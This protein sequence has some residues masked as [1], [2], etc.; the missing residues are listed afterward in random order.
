MLFAALEALEAA[1]RSARNRTLARQLGVVRGRLQQ[2]SFEAA[3]RL[4][5]QLW[6]GHPGETASLAPVYARL[7]L[8]E[9]REP[10]AALRVLARIEEPDAD[11]AAL[12]AHAYGLLRRADDAWRVLSAAL[13]TYCVTPGGLLSRQL[14][15]TLGGTG[16]AAPGWIGVGPTLEFVG[17]LAPG[18]AADT[19]EF[20]FANAP[21]RPTLHLG[22]HA[23]RAQFRFTL[24]DH[25][26]GG[27]LAICSG[28]TPLLGGDQQLPLDFA[29]DGRV[30]GNRQRL[31]G[32]VRVGWL[33]SRRIHLRAQD[34]TGATC[35]IQ[36]RA[37]ALPGHRWPFQLH[38]GRNSL[39][40]KYIV[41]QAR[42]PDKRWQSLPDAPF[43]LPQLVRGAKR[44]AALP[45]W[46]STAGAKV[47]PTPTHL[48][49]PAPIAVVIPAY[50]GVRETLA[51]IESVRSTAPEARLIVV[52]DATPEP[53][54]GAGLD[55]LAA[56]GRIELLRNPGNL[57]FVCSVNRALGGTA[58]H[59]VVLLNSDT[60]VFGDWLQRLRS[61]AYSAGQVGTVTPLCNDGSIASYPQRYGGPIGA[62]EA[63]ELD[64][65]AARTDPP[66]SAEIPVGVGFCMFI[67]HDCLKATGKFDAAIFGVG[68]GEESDFCLRAREHGWSHRLAANV[69]VYHTGGGSFGRRRM[70]LLERSQRLLNLRHPGYNR[71]VKQFMKQ[72]PLLPLRRRLDEQRLLAL[73]GSGV[74]IVT[75]ALEGGVERFVTERKRELHA[76]GLRSLVLKPQRPGDTRHVEICV[77]GTDVPNLCYALPGDLDALTA[78]LRRLRLERIE[79]QHFLDLDPAVIDSV[80]SLQVPCDVVIHDYSWIC[81]RITLINGTGRY[82]G[83]PPVSHCTACVRKNGSRLPRSLST[84]ALRARSERWLA[85]ARTVTAPS[86]DAAERMR[87]YFKRDFEVRPHAPALLHVD[88]ATAEL[89]PQIAAGRRVRV[90]VVGAIGSHKGFQILLQCARDAAERDLP[91]E[92]V[93]VGYTENDQLLL[94]T[95]RVEVTG[96]YD[97]AEVAYLLRRERP[98]LVFL[99]SVWPETWCY[100]LDHAL[101]S[102]IR[103]VAFSVGAMTERLRA[104]GS[105]DLLPL[106]LSAEQ[107]NERL[108]QLGTGNAAVY[109]ETSQPQRGDVPKI[110]DDEGRITMKKSLSDGQQQEEGLSASLQVLPLAPGLY[111]FSVTSAAPATDRSSTA[112]S[113]PAMHVG[114]GPGV[115]SNQVEF[116]GSPGTDGAWLFA[117]GDMLVAKINASAALI[118]TSVR[119]PTGDVLAIEVER[120]ESRTAAAHMP[121]AVEREPEGSLAASR[122]AE[123]YAAAA[124]RSAAGNADEAVVPL[125]IKTHIRS[126]GDMSF[127]DTVWAGRVAPGLWMESFCVQPLRHLNAGD[128]EYKGLTGTGFETPWLSDDQ[129]CGTKGMSV[130]LVGFAVRLKP[131]PENAHYDCEYYGYFHSGTVIGPVRNGAP[132][133]STVA[134]DPLEGMQVRF[135][136][137]ATAPETTAAAERPGP[138]SRKNEPDSKAAK[139]PKAEPV[140]TTRPD[141]GQR[142]VS[143]A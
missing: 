2:R 103:T 45:K 75:L 120:L 122:E 11:A 116:V 54:L 66:L 3:L 35:S 129:N 79:L 73:E 119:A 95:G 110:K 131:G 19:L 89:M 117:R 61:V 77:S 21:I 91:L 22:A 26:A 37:T 42:L 132:C 60:L 49:R 23:G 76:Q 50:R 31:A 74:L 133:R 102:G 43:L 86:A 93:V 32:W 48:P 18:V 99:P 13:S 114:L 97:D 47:R 64:R 65:L 140:S 46:P 143:R 92:F 109:V 5:D 111:L 82:C 70:A 124:Q 40:G 9:D 107:I 55:V 52:D 58:G 94:K 141:S 67:R 127:T 41:V 12:T 6:R 68:Y 30:G 80:L 36:T 15:A 85:R 137:R 134:N 53:T 78:L 101:A 104:V 136:R 39:R 14:S 125:Q 96:R 106:D 63:E 10:E 27:K 88:A 44:P 72:D 115:H 34:E 51:C 128:I 112:L 20:R 113:L 105:D 118:L 28:T 1:T 142:P 57:G 62:A 7:L 29:L 8:L 16:L 81:P 135:V 24:P 59:D 71:Y 100:A 83:E 98:N 69:F 33:P 90:A 38:L 4:T 25:V 56:D 108:L 138:A 17:E 123:P 126:R 139:R 130:P 84:A 87:R 121:V